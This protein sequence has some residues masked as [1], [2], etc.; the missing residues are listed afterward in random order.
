MDEIRWTEYA[1]KRLLEI[2]SPYAEFLLIAAW[3]RTSSR[4][5]AM[6]TCWTSGPVNG[7]FVA[8]PTP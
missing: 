5:K 4:S 6:M 8:S 3:K 2:N 1:Q 7:P